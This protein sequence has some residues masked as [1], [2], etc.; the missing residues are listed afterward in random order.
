MPLSNPN[1]KGKVFCLDYKE[2]SF[3][4]SLCNL[5]LM[6]KNVNFREKTVFHETKQKQ[7]Q[8]I[9]VWKNSPPPRRRRKWKLV[10][11]LRI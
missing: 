11:K 1:L 4:E 2:I 8:K 5:T 7:Q 9:H 10:Y 3:T 6:A